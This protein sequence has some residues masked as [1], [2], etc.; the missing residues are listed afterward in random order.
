MLVEREPRGVVQLPVESRSGLVDC[1]SRP[2]RI[3][4]I[5]HR[6]PGRRSQNVAALCSGEDHAA[7]EIVGPFLRFRSDRIRLST[8]DGRCE[9]A[10]FRIRRVDRLLTRAGHLQPEGAARNRITQR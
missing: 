6:R 5:T 8:D 2:H 4:H 3:A 7:A 1:Q 9:H 10:I